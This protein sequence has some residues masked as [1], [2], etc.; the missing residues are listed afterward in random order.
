MAV[1]ELSVSDSFLSEVTWA[2]ETILRIN[3]A[4][5]RDR[6]LGID[7]HTRQPDGL[8]V[9]FARRDLLFYPYV[10]VGGAVIGTADA[11]MANIATIH[12][13]IERERREEVQSVNAKIQEIA[14]AKAQENNLGLLSPGGNLDELASYF[15]LRGLPIECYYRGKFSVGDISAFDAN[16][17]RLRAYLARVN[18]A[19][20]R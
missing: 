8:F 3:E 17:E 5:M 11:Y 13:Y 12:Y 7:A 15:A 1:S 19:T 2:R 20:T 9:A 6:P 16:I 14:A 10:H 4:R 18:A